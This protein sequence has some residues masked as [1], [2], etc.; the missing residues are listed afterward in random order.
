[1]IAPLLALVL[2]ISPAGT[3]YAVKAHG[4]PRATVQLKAENVPHG[5]VAAFCTATLCSPFAYAL[6]LDEKGDGQIHM[7]LIRTDDAAPH[8]L[9]IS[10][11]APGASP[12]F[13]SALR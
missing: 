1:M 10:V 9:R 6:P 2:H 13:I 8:R 5:W 3:E 11:T 7:R 12:V 4:A